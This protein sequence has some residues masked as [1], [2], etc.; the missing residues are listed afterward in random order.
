MS[1]ALLERWQAAWPEALTHWSKYT[2]LRSP[3]LCVTSVSAAKEGLSGSF[4]MI[5]LNDNSVVI[6]LE[7]IARV[8]LEDYAVEILAHE[9]GHHILAP[10]SAVDHFR[11]L[12]RM[13][14]GLP[15]L[16]QHAPML[17][18]LYTDLLINDRLQR[19][20]DLRM[21]EV[22]RQMKLYGE[23][24]QERGV[25]PASNTLWML[26]VGIY[27]RLWQLEKGSLGGAVDNV[28]EEGN[29]WLGARLVRVYADEWLVGGARFA[30]LALPY[31][32]DDIEQNRQM[33][34]LLADIKHAAQGCE[35][36]GII[37]IE[38]GEGEAIH[39]SD[40]PFITGDAV[41]DGEDQI[42][43]GNDAK[44]QGGGKG[45]LREPFEYGEILKAAGVDLN[46][47]Q[48]AGR[49]YRELAL[50]HL[51]AYPAKLSD[52]ASEP[53]LEGFDPWDIGEP[54]D[55]IDWLGTLTQSPVPIPGTT[56]VKRHMGLQPGKDRAR[57]PPD[58]DIY[59][60]SSGSMPNPR[61]Q[62]SY[63]TLA[64]AI[65]ALSALKAGAQVQATLWSGPRQ[66]LSTNGFVR[67][68]NAI[69]AVLTGYFGGSTSFPIHHMRDTYA[70]RKAHSPDAHILMISDD[71][72]STMFDN[73]ERGNSGWDV[74]QAALD[75]A[76][77][78]GTMA[79]NLW[80]DID[81]LPWSRKAIDGQGWDIH[82]VRDFA[83]LVDFSRAFAARTYGGS[84]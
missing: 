49:Y 46:E 2:R 50:P 12:A 45:Q 17:A 28:V 47:E 70:A 44:S 62:I 69:L 32:V 33:E 1:G 48:L 40:D 4:A 18:N 84:G 81:K 6:D 9:I 54:F 25:K 52:A 78:G 8:G 57:I 24:K 36:V 21:D 5:R 60:D 29:A 10:A 42:G 58:L 83:Q 31:L 67:K 41:G 22:Y 26:Y 27:E 35:P 66:C 79:L 37:Q 63:L 59:V 53:Q 75:I 11:L 68:E 80:T 43:H 82:T 56:I 74:T 65:I 51:I 3:L 39:P 71:G 7:T 55:E 38:E 76:K 23:R 61:Q 16:E 30:A 15:T 13:R 14:K 34:N 72:I 64:G 19:I 73:D 77:G 20:S